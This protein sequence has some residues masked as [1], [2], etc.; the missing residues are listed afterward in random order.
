M[1]VA[2]RSLR[3]EDIPV[4]IINF[5][6]PQLS[7]KVFEAV[8][9]LQPKRLYI[10]CD[11]P[12]ARNPAEYQRVR[13]VRS[14]ILNFIWPCEA[15]TYFEEENK[16]LRDFVVKSIDWFFSK[17]S[18]G[19]I[20]ED[21]CVPSPYFLDF[22]AHILGAFENDSRVMGLSGA[23][24]FNLDFG[25][26]APYGFIRF[27]AVWG[28]ATWRDRWEK[29][30]RD[31]AEFRQ[32]ASSKGKKYWPTKHS[33]HALDWQLK[34]LLRERPDTW[35]YQWSW[36]VI[37]EN[38]YWAIPSGN[39][40]RNIGLGQVGTHTKRGIRSNQEFGALANLSQPVRVVV[41]EEA[42]LRFSQLAMRVY[43]PFWINHLRNLY[44]FLRP[45]TKAQRR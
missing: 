19:V 14:E 18:Y 16:G 22:A 32:L 27:P 29:Y 21:D 30:D 10:T 43:K 6:R 35:D 11:G 15:I 31:L 40:V 34:R 4:L 45:F 26:D 2:S 9:R 3:P 20:L 39:L 36:S 8:S 7:R 24:S 44:R 37:K 25:P 12:R 17:E 28:W 33:L 1:S 38:G 42:D 13:E 5:D 41:H 23:N